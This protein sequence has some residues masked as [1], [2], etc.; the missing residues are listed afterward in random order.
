LTTPDNLWSITPHHVGIVV[1]DLGSAMDA[2]IANFGY[3]FFQISINEANASLSGSS[4]QFGLR[5][6]F[7]QLGLNFIE[8]IQPVSG[9]TIYSKYLS[10]RGP[11]LHHLAFSVTDIA[12][13]RNLLNQQGFICLQN[14][15]IKELV[16]FSYYQADHLGCIVEPLQLSSD[17][18]TFLATN[19]TPYSGK[20]V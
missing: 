4:P 15:I 13:A 10:R 9:T 18:I 12:V 3:T 17:L 20:S 8:L 11:G 7:G 19:C 1:S 14:G 2:Y 16:D 5:L 6:G